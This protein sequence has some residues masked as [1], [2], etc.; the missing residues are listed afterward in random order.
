MSENNVTKESFCNGFGV[1][2]RVAEE[3]KTCYFSW[4]RFESSSW[5]FSHEMKSN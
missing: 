4:S 3:G 2:I 5:Y 1:G